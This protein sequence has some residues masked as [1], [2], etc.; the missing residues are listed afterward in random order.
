MMAQIN[1]QSK[2]ASVVRK[3][4]KTHR[5][6][7]YRTFLTVIENTDILYN[8]YRAKIDYEHWTNKMEFEVFGQRILFI[9]ANEPSKLHGP[10]RDLLWANEANELSVDEWDQLIYRTKGNKILDYNPI[11]AWT[12]H[13]M[14]DVVDN[15]EKHGFNSRD[16]FHSTYKDNPW[17]TDKQRR[18]IEAAKHTDPY[19]Y[20]VYALGKRGKPKNV[21]YPKWEVADSYPE[22]PDKEAYG[23]DFGFSGS[24]NA[25]VKVAWEGD[26]IYV[27]ELLY[28]KGMT[29]ADLIDWMNK[30]DI[31]T[32]TPIYADHEPE[33]IEQ[34]YRA[35]YNIHKATKSVLAG[36]NRVKEHHIRVIGDNITDE[37]ARYR[38]KQDKNGN[39][40]EKP[41]DEDDHLMDAMRY[42]VMTHL[43]EAYQPTV[44]FS[45]VF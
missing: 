32:Y 21:V 18:I 27:K 8:G 1:G 34:I 11:S 24:K 15:Y 29:V 33:Q 35:G 20:Q 31:D 22:N 41:I 37:I 19:K 6:G 40:L 10:E 38:W 13:W 30:N 26:K 42:A 12:G 39:L 5:E 7:A 23:L 36:I 17:V 2:K 14:Y 25:F 16:L 3:Y 44:G 9:G 4:K 43:S 45:E 28:K